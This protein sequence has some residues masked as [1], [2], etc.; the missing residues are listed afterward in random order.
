MKNLPQWMLAAAKE[1]LQA[2]IKAEDV[3]IS[4]LDALIEHETKKE[5]GPQ[6]VPAKHTMSAAGRKRVSEA[7]KK[8]WEKIRRFKADRL[9][10]A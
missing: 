5:S 7:Q 3:M 1:G 2:R 8:R 4:M 10:T 9:M 6:P